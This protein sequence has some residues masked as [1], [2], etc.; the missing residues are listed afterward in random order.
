MI[1]L[2]KKFSSLLGLVLTALI[3][4]A[5]GGSGAGAGGAGSSGASGGASALKASVAASLALTADSQ[6]LDSDGR[7]AITVLATTKN[8]ANL[9]LKGATVRFSTTDN[10]T[11][12]TPSDTKTDE[13]GVVSA[14][15]RTT[16][17]SSRTIK[18]VAQSEALTSTIE[19]NVIGTTVTING[20]TGLGFGAV[21]EYSVSVKDS[22]GA[23]IAGQTVVLKSKNT[24]TTPPSVTDAQGQS[25]FKITGS[26]AGTDTLEIASLGNVTTLAINVTS[27]QLAFEAPVLNAEY[28]VGTA[29]SSNLVTLV[30][31]E[32]GAPVVGRA[33]N[34]TATRGEVQTLSGVTNGTQ[35]TG[36]DGRVS[37]L[38]RSTS[39]GVST[40]TATTDD[41]VVAQKFE[42]VARIPTQ[43]SF[44]A[45]PG[46]VGVNLTAASSN[47][48]Q[49]IARVTD[50]INPVKGVRVDFSALADA[51]GGRI[52]PAFGVTD[53]Y[54]QATSSFIAGAIP[55]GNDLV[56]LQAKV[57]TSASP[58]TIA[59]VSKLTVAQQEISI[60]MGESNT[61]APDSNNT[62]YKRPLTVL[63]TDSAGRPIA[64]ARVTATVQSV[65]YYKGEYRI[66]TPL[67][68]STGRWGASISAICASEDVNSNG[69]LDPSEDINGNGL[70]DPGNVSV[71]SV[72]NEAGN[73]D[74][75]SKTSDTGFAYLNLAYPKVYGLWTKVRITVSILAPSGT[76]GKQSLETLLG[77]LATDVSDTS[78]SPPGRLIAPTTSNDVIRVISPFGAVA[79][80]RNAN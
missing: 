24:V 69:L 39:A 80:C 3:L 66:V 1:S 21:A 55:T 63:V 38:V 7:K 37:F 20:P 58:A 6:T 65:S 51:S 32:S 43:I 76:E 49:L 5:C 75:S 46:V 17:K 4:N 56:V 78:T 8:D 9:A 10:G 72:V 23:P 44:Q 45:G 77:V 22:A 61:V 36:S 30:L 48:A 25:R 50:G 34:L 60:R 31:R 67:G 47:S 16:D 19:I 73:I 15:I 79:D 18:I 28:L 41:I 54:G 71:I 68:S 13:S 74:P 70:L 57:A 11:T 42:F 59:S 12:V 33:V 62:L 35:T 40:L 26:T 29:Q 27:K 64:G 53:S 2:L 14:T 52:E